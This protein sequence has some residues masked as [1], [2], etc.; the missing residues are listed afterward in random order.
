M[1]REKSQLFILLIASLIMLFSS[2]DFASADAWWGKGYRDKEW[3]LSHGGTIIRFEIENTSGDDNEY[4]AVLY[5]D[6]GDYVEK[7]FGTKGYFDDAKNG[8]YKIKADRVE[9]GADKT[10][11]KGGKSFASIEITA[12]PGETIKLK[13][14]YKKKKVKMTTDYV[15]PIPRPVVKP[16]IVPA[17]EPVETQPESTSDTLEPTSAINN[18]AMTVIENGNSL[19]E[20][21]EDYIHPDALASVSNTQT[22]IRQADSNALE[23][24]PKNIFKKIWDY[25]V[26]FFSFN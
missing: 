3:V 13:F 24:K 5:D 12:H 26:K 8:K 4:K 11:Y 14:D 1:D 21:M 15:K 9:G 6:D 10:T 23:E 18:E 20:T 16:T 2:A 17:P 25:I 7:E 19:I 22:F